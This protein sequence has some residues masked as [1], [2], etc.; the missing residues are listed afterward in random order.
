MAHAQQD[1][2]D[3]YVIATNET[4]SV[5]DFVIELF[6]RLGPIRKYVEYDDRYE[7]P[8]E[9][10]LPTGIQRRSN[11]SSIGSLK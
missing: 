8:A 4:H 5:K 7:R 9:V 10:D 11:V 2:P 3:D 6:D 1:E